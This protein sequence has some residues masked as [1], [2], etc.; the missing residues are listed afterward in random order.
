MN[1]KYIIM[2]NS[3]D[4]NVIAGLLE[5]GTIDDILKNLKVCILTGNKDIKDKLLKCQGVLG[6]EEDCEGYYCK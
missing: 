4:D 5:Y 3:L 6:V 2:V 1:Q